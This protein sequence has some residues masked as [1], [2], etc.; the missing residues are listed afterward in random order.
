[1]TLATQ[2][3][4]ISAEKVAEI[5]SSSSESEGLIVDCR[6][7]LAFNADHIETSVNANV[8]SILARRR[9]GIMP[10]Q[11]L[12]SNSE[13]RQKLASGQC[14]FIVIYDDNGQ[15]GDICNSSSDNIM[16]PQS[17][18]S[19]AEIIS[20]SFSAALGT[21]TD[22]YYLKGTCVAATF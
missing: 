9:G 11:S 16:S 17:Q 6:S 22:I 2:M 12:L 5:V 4:P 18:L 15:L 21:N 19:S 10:T 8:P 14:K 7:L 13:A 20:R 1:M 3:K